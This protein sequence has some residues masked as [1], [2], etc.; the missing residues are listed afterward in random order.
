MSVLAFGLLGLAAM[1]T[2]A[3]TRNVDAGDLARGT[4]LASQMMERIHFNRA[5]AADYNGNLGTGINTLNV[6][7]RPPTTQT[8]ARGDYNQ[9]QNNLT[10]SGLTNVF[11]LVNVSSSG[12]T[13]L[14]Q[15]L[16]IVQVIWSTK[17]G[18]NKIS[19]TARVRLDTVMTP[20]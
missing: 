4:A 7:T 12:P 11:G 17:A 16:V 9:W 3:L 20:Q 19:R 1:Q 13:S 5:N 8:T 18:E 14:N 6:L 15:S 2:V 10:N